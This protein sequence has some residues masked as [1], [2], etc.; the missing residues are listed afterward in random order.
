MD[1]YLDLCREGLFTIWITPSF[2]CKTILKI[3]RSDPFYLFFYYW[4]VSLVPH[5]WLSALTHF[6]FYE[7][8]WLFIRVNF[9]GKITAL[10]YRSLL[11]TFNENR[12]RGKFPKKPGTDYLQSLVYL[13]VKIYYTHEFN[14]DQSQRRL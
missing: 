14:G 12:Y 7:I 2:T 8:E 13:I 3:G 11:W 10:S 9:C 6:Y 1:R 4:N 5:C